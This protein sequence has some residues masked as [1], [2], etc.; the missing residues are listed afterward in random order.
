[1][2]KKVKRMTAGLISMAIIIIAL[3]AALIFNRNALK[4]ERAVTDAYATEMLANQQ[5][6]YTAITDIRHG[7]TLTEGENVQL[8]NVYT[9]LSSSVYMTADELGSTAIIDIPKGV[10]VMKEMVTA[11]SI[12]QDTREY[13]IQVARLMQDST[14]NDYVDIR[15]MFPTGVD[16]LVL[17]KKQIKNLNLENCVWWTYL[18]EEEILRLASAIIDAYTITGTRIYA[19]RY[20][21]TN[22][23]DESLPTYLVN[24][25]VQDMFDS[26]SAYYDGN[27]LTKA[28]QTLN[29]D[30]RLD[31]EKKLKSLTSEKLSAVA[32]GHELEDTAKN[33]ALTGTG[34]YDAQAA[35][36][37]YENSSYLGYTAPIATEE[38]EDTETETVTEEAETNSITDTVNQLE[39]N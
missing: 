18:N 36:E 9:G 28:I 21:E 34:E 27:L 13:E 8:Q 5:T 12:S 30:A 37:A 35:E 4:E 19:T 33:S 38:A 39:G 29:T 3:I 1:M 25:Y 31:M 7:D 15:I 26:S 6:V 22:L 2:K 20:V 11:V 17:P 10:T 23:Q 16:Q 24:T 14:E 32:A